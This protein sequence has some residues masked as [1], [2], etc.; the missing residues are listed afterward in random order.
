MYI[1]DISTPE[2]QI[3]NTRICHI[4]QVED[5]GYRILQKN[6]GIWTQYSGRKLS[7]FFPLDSY[8]F[9]S[10]STRVLLDLEIHFLKKC[11]FV[12]AIYSAIKN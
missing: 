11:F 9:L 12:L 8:D 5:S 7:G 2:T 6:V 3:E 10:E 4:A 1:D